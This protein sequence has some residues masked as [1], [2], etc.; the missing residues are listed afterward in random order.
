M[1]AEA[2]GKSGFV[3]ICDEDELL[4]VLL[5]HR[6][7]GEGYEVAVAH[8]R[9]AGVAILDRTTP[10]AIILGELTT[11]RSGNDVLR[12][13]REEPRLKDVP[14]IMLTAR[15]READIVQALELGADD[16]VT[17]PF[18]PKELVARLAKAMRDRGG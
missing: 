16:Y 18:I 3:L 1:A 13:I 17:K 14:V 9:D 7:G 5:E 6:L 12:R 11:V 8:D 10:D 15:N 4:T 2:G